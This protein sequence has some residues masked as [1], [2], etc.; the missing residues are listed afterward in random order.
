MDIRGKS[1]PLD[2]NVSGVNSREVCVRD[3]EHGERRQ[4]QE[5][6]GRGSAHVGFLSPP[7]DFGL[8]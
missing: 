2:G 6:W 7:K 3:R 1:V 5:A 8:D 4:V